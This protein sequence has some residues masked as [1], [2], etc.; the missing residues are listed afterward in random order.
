MLKCFGD[1]IGETIKAY[2]DDI[3]V[4]SK[5]V[6]QLMVNLKK[7][8]T[9]LRKNGIKLNP[10]KCVFEVSRGMLLGF[11]ISEPGIEGNLKKITAI[12]WMGLI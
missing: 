8:F 10:K 11:I 5:R 1:L 2:M 12:T 3:I 9:K 4:K 6:D 7:T